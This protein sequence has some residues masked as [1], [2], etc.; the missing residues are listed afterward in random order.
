MRNITP[1]ENL[2]LNLEFL[3]TSGK[4]SQGDIYIYL[5]KLESLLKPKEYEIERVKMTEFFKGV[6][7]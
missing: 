5:N 3:K 2:Y 4:L 7:R 1:V 6:K